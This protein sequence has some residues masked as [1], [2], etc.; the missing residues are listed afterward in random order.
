M[1]NESQSDPPQDQGQA[2]LIDVGHFLKKVWFR[3]CSELQVEVLTRKQEFQ[4]QWKQ[5]SL[6]F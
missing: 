1:S 3:T 6:I 4:L 2:R 5:I